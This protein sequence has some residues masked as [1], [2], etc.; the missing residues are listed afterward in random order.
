M[1]D[2]AKKSLK[3][4]SRKSPVGETSGAS[5]LVIFDLAAAGS[6][7]L[8]EV[9][10][11]PTSAQPESKKDS[12]AKTPVCGEKCGA[13]SGACDLVGCLLRTR[14][15]SVLRELTRSLLHWKRSATP[16]GRSWWVLSMPERLTGDKESGSWATLRSHEAGDWQKD[17]QGKVWRTLTGQAKDWPTPT[18][19]QYGS[20]QGGRA[21]GHKRPGL[22]QLTK[23]WLTPTSHN[24]KGGRGKLSAQRIKS[25]N[26]LVDLAGRCHQETSSTF[27]KSQD[28]SPHVPGDLNPDYK[29]PEL[30]LNPEWVCQLMGMPEGWL[31]IDEKCLKL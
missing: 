5:Q 1:T 12:A 30:W 4:T 13:L 9:S 25:G 23:E 24:Q 28:A 19:T 3:R 21:K 2:F 15:L 26:D 29:Q 8:P 22:T 20:N 7:A 17:P 14:L 31:D 11:V 10:P 27:G 16:S 6:I 18:A